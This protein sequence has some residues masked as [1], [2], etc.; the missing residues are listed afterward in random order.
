MSIY[1]FDSQN[2]IIR[3]RIKAHPR[4][5]FFLNNKKRFYSD[6]ALPLSD[7]SV[8]AG[9]DETIHHT[10]RGYLSLYE[11]N[12][13]R[14][15]SAGNSGLVYPFITK[16]G[17]LSSFK[18]VSTSAF[19]GFAYGDEIS[20]S[21]PLSSS[22]AIDYYG[23]D[24][25]RKRIS[26]LRNTFDYYKTLSPHYSY[27]SELGDKSSQEIKLISI[28]SIFYGTEIK[29]GTVKLNFYVT[30]SLVASLEDQ[31]RNGELVQT[32]GLAIGSAASS[33]EI[34][35]NSSH[36]PFYQSKRIMLEDTSGTIKSF[37]FDTTGAFGTSYTTLDGIISDV[38][39]IN[40]LE[41]QP[42]QI[43]TAFANA[44]NGALSLQISAVD[45]NFANISLTQDVAGEA[46]DTTIQDPESI[47]G[48]NIVQFS[49]GTSGAPSP[50]IGKVAGVVLYRE[51]FVAL[52][53]SWDLHP[54]YADVF[55]DDDDPPIPPRWTLWGQESLPDVEAATFCPSASWDIGF[56]GTTYTPVLT[57]FAHAQEGHLNH[58]NNPTCI[59][60]S[61]RI[62]TEQVKVGRRRIIE[63]KERRLANIVKSDYPNHSASFDKITYISKIG[64]YDKHRNLIAI[65]KL[66]TPV[67]KTE[68]RS[69]TFKMKLD[70]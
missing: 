60:Y 69:Y 9:G 3:N 26:A 65:A 8:A 47:D 57:M 10:P 43:A 56:L 40:G 20:G 68:S 7:A 31:A 54:T 25:D 36:L 32:S 11:I 51:G 21:Y 62:T 15:E 18:T 5:Y 12:I 37:I 29:K 58:S 59:S 28:P 16:Q 4:T 13:N 64:V 24:S 53:G 34:G 45:G 67:K 23:Q 66:A 27:I 35:F 14:T 61:D 70:I 30:G 6:Q 2:D 42:E 44:V 17:A 55:L 22:I 52:T 1:E 50:D 48:L 39:Q 63:N 38:V 19:Q 41:G 33:A 46:G 49:G